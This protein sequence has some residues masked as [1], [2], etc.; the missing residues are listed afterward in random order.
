MNAFETGS[1]ARTGIR[2]WL[3]YYNAERPHSTHGI[4]TPDE[5]YESG[6]AGNDTLIG[7]NGFDTLYGEAGD[8]LLFG[9]MS[10]DA[11]YGGD[12]ADTIYGQAGFDA[13]FGGLASDTFVFTGGHDIIQD[14]QNNN[15]S[16]VIDG[17]LLSLVDIGANTVTIEDLRGLFEVEGE[18]IIG[19]FGAGNTLETLGVSNFYA[20]LGDMTIE[21]IDYTY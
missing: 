19:T 16:I 10:P 5:A 7:N 9:G 4:L 3:A 11:L 13:L 15:D 14:F 17:E 20:F 18:N 6:E 8:D 21:S 12:G 1:A 2:K